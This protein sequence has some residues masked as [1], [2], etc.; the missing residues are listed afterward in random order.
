MGSE[1]HSLHYCSIMEL[2]VRIIVAGVKGEHACR[3]HMGGTE[4]RVQSRDACCPSMSCLCTS[5]R[6]E[7]AV[8]YPTIS[9]NGV[10]MDCH[11]D[12]EI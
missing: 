9:D 7:R 12:G 4:G 1:G 10:Q 2:F 11:S 6:L 3:P 5:C 8:A